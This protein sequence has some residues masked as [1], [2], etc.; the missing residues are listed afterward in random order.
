MER[1]A[2]PEFA[3]PN[4]FKKMTEFEKMMELYRVA[5]LVPHLV[6]EKGI[7]KSSK[8]KSY[9][10]R[11]GMQFVKVELSNLDR[12]DFN[13]LLKFFD[14]IEGEGN[15]KLDKVIAQ[16]KKHRGDDP[17]NKGSIAYHSHTIPKWVV[18]ILEANADGRPTLLFFDEINRAPVDVVN[19]IMNTLLEREY[20]S[21]R[22]V[23]P[24]TT[25]IVTAGNPDNEDYTVNPMDQALKGRVIEVEMTASYDEWKKN[26]ATRILENEPLEPEV[27]R[28]EADDK[29]ID[30]MIHP[31]IIQFLDE[32]P[33]M[34]IIEG[35]ENSEGEKSPGLDP[36]RWEMISN[37][38][39]GYEYTTPENERDKY[40]GILRVALTSTAG[41]AVGM[42]LFQFYKDNR[43]ITLD[44]LLKRYRDDIKKVEPA[45]SEDDR[46]F[47]ELI[48]KIKPIYDSLEVIEKKNFLD[49]A[50]NKF[51]GKHISEKELALIVALSETEHIAAAVDDSGLKFENISKEIDDKYNLE[52]YQRLV[53][54][55]AKVVG[56]GDNSF[57][58]SILN[59]SNIMGNS[60]K[61]SDI[62][63]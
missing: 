62:K 37:L 42:Q 1:R 60:K 24:P 3:N 50:I 34:F 8:V 52:I 45:Q 47:G 19:A 5:D 10:K 58:E 39:K 54:S 7:G 25:Y 63:K 30:R 32:N 38:L 28:E 13:G 44:K 22:I 53:E 41:V 18:E 59:D 57:L 49:Q 35:E 48:E 26:F 27:V 40:F 4:R 31:V 17:S 16:L 29:N 15:D 46:P 9:A 43:K 61:D 20:G 36:R 2:R 23:L 12:V 55:M 33:N 21:D 14:Y 6:G 51:N 11:L 56:D